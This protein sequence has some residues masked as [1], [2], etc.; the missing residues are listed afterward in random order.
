MRASNATTY[1]FAALVVADITTALGGSLGSAA[2]QAT[3]AFAPAAGSSS[4]VTIGTIT[5]GTF[6]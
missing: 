1:G 5:S 4:I 2:F 3:T 6:P